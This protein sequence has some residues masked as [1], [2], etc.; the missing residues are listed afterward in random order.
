L[1]ACSGAGE[2]FG[3][4]RVADIFCETKST[5]P[6]AG[7]LRIYAHRIITLEEEAARTDRIAS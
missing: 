1:A 6:I 7:A 2:A 3:V 5:R 4:D